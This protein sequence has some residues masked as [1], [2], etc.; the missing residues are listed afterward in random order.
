MILQIPNSNVNLR[1]SIFLAQAAA[2]RD[3][4]LPHDHPDAPGSC[5]E[6]PAELWHFIPPPKIANPENGRRIRDDCT[7]SVRYDPNTGDSSSLDHLPL[8]GEF[9]QKP[10]I[11][12]PYAHRNK[13]RTKR[14]QIVD[15]LHSAGE[16]RKAERIASCGQSGWIMMHKTDQTKV[17]L[18]CRRCGNRLCPTCCRRRG[19][20]VQEQALA[21]IKSRNVRRP[22]MMTLTLANEP[23]LGPAVRRIWRFMKRL[24]QRA[25]WRKNVRGALIAIEIKHG[26]TGWHPH[27]H[28]LYE[29]NFIDQAKLSKAW[30][31]ITGNSFIVDIRAADPSAIRYVTKYL[32]KPIDYSVVSGTGDVA[33]EFITATAEKNLFAFTGQWRKVKLDPFKYDPSEWEQLMS[34]DDLVSQCKDGDPWART[35]AHR[36]KIEWERPPA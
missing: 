10:L 35:L 14:R 31:S 32:T 25:I 11:F 33:Q 20:R 30:H 4:D 29:G 7:E 17:R 19:R 24:K 16:Y 3:Q 2:A 8:N 15:M 22:R 36:A 12:A 5:L 28:V 23:R 13:D 6:P 21:C 27:V 34:L 18:S 26:E 1:R 9:S